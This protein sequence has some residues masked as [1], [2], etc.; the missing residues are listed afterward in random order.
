MISDLVVSAPAILSRQDLELL[1]QLK[2]DGYT[3][4]S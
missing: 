4:K 2:G 3:D 1:V